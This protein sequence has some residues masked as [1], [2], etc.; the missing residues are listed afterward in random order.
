MSVDTAP[1]IPSTNLLSKMRQQQTL[2]NVKKMIPC[3]M[4]LSISQL[5][6]ILIGEWDDHPHET[7]DT[8]WSTVFSAAWQRLSKLE[9]PVAILSAV[10]LLVCWKASF[11]L[12]ALELL[13]LKSQ[14]Q[15]TLLHTA[16]YPPFCFPVFGCSML[17]VWLSLVWQASQR[18]NS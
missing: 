12:V 14:I 4:Q 10:M 8:C 18:G 7:H 5:Q 15:L 11:Q 3:L 13:N 1:A 9:R 16:Y 2:A 17:H 6:G